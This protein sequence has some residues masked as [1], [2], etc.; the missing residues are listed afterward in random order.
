MDKHYDPIILRRVEAL[1]AEGDWQGLM[2]YVDGLSNAQFRTAGYILGERIMPRLNETNAWLLVMRLTEHNSKA[3]LVTMMKAVAVRI[4]QGNMQLRF[5]GSR[6][7][8]AMVRDN[9]V[10]RQKILTELLP[11]VESPED[12]AWLLGKL[13]VEEGRERLAA[14]LRV[15]TTAASYALFRT[16]HYIEHE[17]PLLVRTVRFLMQ[18]GDALGFNLASLLKTYY[19]LDE[20][21]GTF[22]LHIEPY[23]LARLANSYEAFRRAMQL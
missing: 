19:G 18:R 23:E 10:D 15:Q 6:A 1:V 17:R 16:M 2:T 5:A 3:F 22:S 4:K 11:V 21:T 9:E 14:L 12:V 8:L 13:G 7:F 20:V